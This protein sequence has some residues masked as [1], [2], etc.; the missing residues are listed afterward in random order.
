MIVHRTY[1]IHLEKPDDVEVTSHNRYLGIMNEEELFEPFWIEEVDACPNFEEIKSQTKLNW[2]N[3]K[4]SFTLENSY[5][6][7]DWLSKYQDK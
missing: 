7:N 3:Q 5:I 1:I 4:A 2:Q 6:Y